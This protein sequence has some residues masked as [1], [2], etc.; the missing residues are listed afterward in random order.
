RERSPLLPEVPAVSETVPGFESVTW[1]GILGPRGL[2]ADVVARL[3]SD[4]NAVLKTPEFV[5]RARALGFE[6]AGGSPQE[7]AAL[8]VRDTDKWAKLIRE[9]RITAE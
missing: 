3:N 4:I 7:F 8:L 2:P 6:P 5:D 9:R 1:F